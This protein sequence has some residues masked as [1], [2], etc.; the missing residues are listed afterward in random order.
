M[1]KRVPARAYVISVACA[2]KPIDSTS[3]RL[4]DV[5]SAIDFGTVAVGSKVTQS[6]QFTS[7]VAPAS[8]LL[9]SITDDATESF[10]MQ[11][12]STVLTS[13][14]ETAQVT[15]APT[16]AG[17]LTGQFEVVNDCVDTPLLIPLTGMGV[18][19]CNLS[20]SPM[21]LTFGAVP[22][23][24]ESPPQTIAC[25]NTGGEDCYFAIDTTATAPE[26]SVTGP[27]GAIPQDTLQSV[28]PD[29][30]YVITV[31]FDPGDAGNI[32]S[33]FFFQVRANMDVCIN[34]VSFPL[35]GAGS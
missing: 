6:V 24:T 9:L 2:G 35:T 21:S 27:N 12:P 18:S 15:F 1:I 3:C 20:V 34:P 31:V 33:Q 28:A 30:G 8:L 22:V 19:Q 25:T 32:D 10:S 5:P 29:S 11:L 26:Y 13:Q 14:P 16:T 7:T 17:P 4:S 23:R